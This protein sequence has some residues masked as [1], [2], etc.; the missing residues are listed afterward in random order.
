VYG[1]TDVERPDAACVDIDDLN[2]MAGDAGH[3]R[4]D[5]DPCAI[6]RPVLP[7]KALKARRELTDPGPV[8]VR[9]HQGEFAVGLAAAGR[10][11]Q[12]VEPRPVSRERRAEVE[13]GSADHDRLFG[14]DRVD[15][16]DVAIA[17][18]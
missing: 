7:I 9:N 2:D 4:Q 8:C 16:I 1:S 3:L 14:G 18:G 6:R 17:A 5:R 13:F 10:A 15:G 12:E 11:A